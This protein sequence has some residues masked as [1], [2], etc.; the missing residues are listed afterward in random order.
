MLM[1]QKGGEEYAEKNVLYYSS[2]LSYAVLW[3]CRKQ[4]AS[5]ITNSVIAI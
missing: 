1:W 3:L 5:C 4:D 2:A